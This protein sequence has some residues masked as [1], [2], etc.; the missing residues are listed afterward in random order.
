MG[1]DRNDITDEH[2]G[3]IIKET[4]NMLAG[5]TLS[6]FDDKTVFQLTIPELIDTGKAADSV[7]GEGEE[8]IVVVAETIEGC[9][10]LKAVVE[11]GSE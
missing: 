7:K 9:L 8:E 10:A 6:N 4:I 3:G 1:L 11:S 5:S 2:S